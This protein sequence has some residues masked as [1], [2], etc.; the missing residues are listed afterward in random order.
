[1]FT[2][3]VQFND[4]PKSEVEYHSLKDAVRNMLRLRGINTDPNTH[5]W[6]L[7]S[8]GDIVLPHKLMPVIEELLPCP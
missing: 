8:Q 2:V 5:I 4:I 3:F 6:V 1:M 7:D